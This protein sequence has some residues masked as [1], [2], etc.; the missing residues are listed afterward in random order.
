MNKRYSFILLLVLV[1]VRLHGEISITGLKGLNPFTREYQH[2]SPVWGCVHWKSGYVENIYR[3]EVAQKTKTGE[4]RTYT[5]KLVKE[6]FFVHHDNITMDTTYSPYHIAMFFTPEIIGKLVVAV[7]KFKKKISDEKVLRQLVGKVIEREKVFRVPRRN[8]FKSEIVRNFKEEVILL[9]PVIGSEGKP[10]EHIGKVIEAFRQRQIGSEKLPEDEGAIYGSLK[11]IKKDFSALL[12]NALLEEELHRKNFEFTKAVCPIPFK[13]NN[14]IFILLSYLWKRAE[15]KKDFTRYFDEIKR[16]LGARYKR[17]L[18]E[19]FGEVVISKHYEAIELPKLFK[20]TTFFEALEREEFS[21][22]DYERFEETEEDLLGTDIEKLAFFYWGYDL[23]INP[24][25]PL[26]QMVMGTEFIGTDGVVYG[27]PDCGE[28]SLRNFLNALLYSPE[29]KEFDIEKLKKLTTNKDLI[30][31]YKKYK[32]AENILNFQA[33][34][35]WAQVVSNIKGGIYRYESAGGS[36]NISGSGG[37]PNMLAILKTLLN[38]ISFESFDELAQRLEEILEVY[39]NIKESLGPEKKFGNIT[40]DFAEVRIK[41]VFKVGHFEMWYPDEEKIKFF[42]HKAEQLRE[43]IAKDRELRPFFVLYFSNLKQILSEDLLRGSLSVI[44]SAI[45]LRRPADWIEHLVEGRFPLSVNKKT[46][47]LINVI[48]DG[49]VLLAK[50]YL[51]SRS[52]DLILEGEKILMF[53]LERDKGIEVA[54]EAASRLFYDDSCIGLDVALELFSELIKKNVG[55][56]EALQAAKD[57]VKDDDARVRGKSLKLF[58]ELGEK[59]VGVNE[60]FQAAND[61]VKDDDA[62]VR[63]ES[64][65]LFKELVEKNVGVNEAFQA[66]NDRVKD[67]DAWVR[68]ESLKLFKELVEKNVGV[69]EAL[70]AAK[71]RVKDDDSGVIKEVL[72]L[73]QVLLKKNVVDSEILQAM[74][75]IIMDVLNIK[76]RNSTNDR[77]IWEE[78]IGILEKLVTKNIGFNQAVSIASSALNHEHYF[79]RREVPGLFKLLITKNVGLKEAVNAAVIGVDDTHYFCNVACDFLDLFKVLV[80]KNIG[81][82]EAIV[83]AEKGVSSW[84][85]LVRIYALQLFIELVKNGHGFN[86]AKEAIIKMKNDRDEGVRNAANTL[87]KQLGIQMPFKFLF[88]R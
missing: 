24:L 80:N 45:F 62:W 74:P 59:N 68:S 82:N 9:L 52:H 47:G 61:R 31:F 16:G 2:L 64:L 27:F 65:K 81:V 10:S 57:R 58:K 39:I 48:L 44:K 72:S 50:E 88:F 77:D 83:A 56:N 14:T 7:K 25:P 15:S 18:R 73:F 38:R 13:E 28:T 87:K 35:D 63:S 69:N 37:A 71:D 78:S 30:G 79:V 5:Q 17:S 12:L 40:F 34:H 67:D 29:T 8:F 41:W 84:Y 55:I 51:S 36:C 33:H 4:Q 46:L 49:F 19:A 43:K 42:S 60:A 32:T 85:S 11:R 23:Y 75:K 86:Q 66:A 53:L 3:Y 20:E 70:E 22:Q 1:F 21:K 54:I 26:V 76:Y 6:L